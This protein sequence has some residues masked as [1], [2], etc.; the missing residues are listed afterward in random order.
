MKKEILLSIICPAYNAEETVGKLIESIVEKV[1][2][3]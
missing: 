3:V 2:Q 1:Y